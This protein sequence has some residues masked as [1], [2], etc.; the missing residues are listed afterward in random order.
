MTALK[1][2]YILKPGQRTR[3]VLWRDHS[4]PLA[5]VFDEVSDEK[6]V[7]R[8]DAG[9][10]MRLQTYDHV[11]DKYSV[12]LL[13]VRAG[14]PLHVDPAYLR[15]SHQYVLRNDGWY[16]HGMND[17]KPEVPDAVGTLHC[18]D[19]HSPHKVSRDER[20][21][22]GAGLYYIALVIDDDKPRPPEWVWEQ[23]QPWL[24][25]RL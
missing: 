6:M 19:T 17:E 21:L 12:H 22:S 2:G 24:K 13:A 7:A 4:H 5:R 15:Y 3:P 25:E 1:K 11:G 9:K 8:F 23:M 16:L 20:I 14:T 10:S 18:L